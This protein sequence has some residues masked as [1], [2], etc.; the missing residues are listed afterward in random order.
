M[1][2]TIYQLLS[3]I[4]VFRNSSLQEEKF[5]LLALIYI[6]RD[7][8]VTAI[9]L[10]KIM[11]FSDQIKYALTELGTE[12]FIEYTIYPKLE[13]RDMFSRKYFITSAGINKIQEIIEEMD[14]STEVFKEFVKVNQVKGY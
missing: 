7:K 3:Y 11:P 2:K 14:A 1:E 5:V 4:W 10:F 6:M 12:K 9:D 8:G 13:T